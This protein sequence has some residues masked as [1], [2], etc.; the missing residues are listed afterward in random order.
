MMMVV[1]MIGDGM[2]TLVTGVWRCGE[3]AVMVFDYLLFILE[4][5]KRDRDLAFLLFFL[6]SPPQHSPTP[7]PP[8]Q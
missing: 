3:E 7:Q 4:I 6:F 5:Q 1:R 2:A 8:A